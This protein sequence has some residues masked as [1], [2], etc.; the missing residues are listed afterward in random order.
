VNIAKGFDLE[1]PL[2][3]LRWGASEEELR[4]L[5]P[6]AR[7]VAPG[8]VVSD[9]ESMGC[10]S[11]RIGLHLNPKDDGGS[12]VEIEIFRA[13]YSNWLDAD[14]VVSFNDFET[15]LEATFGPST[16]TRP[17]DLGT[18][19][20]LWRVDGVVI[21]HMLNYRFGYEEY[22]RIKGPGQAPFG[23]TPGDHIFW[24]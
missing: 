17:G 8:Y 7:Q 5:L 10:S 1:R 11:H 16:E 20:H 14:W 9:C 21:V 2:V 15:R 6:A 4:V 23:D 19:S 3:Q 22:V 18:T 12:L 13:D 24:P